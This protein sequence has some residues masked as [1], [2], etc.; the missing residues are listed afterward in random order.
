MKT[1]PS[2]KIQ[3]IFYF[4]T[5]R[6]ANSLCGC[7]SKNDWVF[8]TQIEAYFEDKNLN[9]ATIVTK[10]DE[11]P[12]ILTI[13]MEKCAN[14]R[15]GTWYELRFLYRNIEIITAGCLGHPAKDKSKLDALLVVASPAIMAQDGIFILFLSIKA[16]KT[17]SYI[18]MLRDYCE[19]RKFEALMLQINSQ[20]LREHPRITTF[21]VL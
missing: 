5:K 11:Y 20:Y 14:E 7:K 4:T 17:E 6:L 8:I 19:K 9:D 10:F 21:E 2:A 12:E 16:A 13:N 15:G 18:R 3:L 1:Y